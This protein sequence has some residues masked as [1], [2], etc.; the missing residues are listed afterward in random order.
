MA[1]CLLV[2]PYA[3]HL[4]P[5]IATNQRVERGRDNYRTAVGR[6]DYGWDMAW[7]NLSRQSHA[8]ESGS[9]VR[10]DRHCKWAWRVA[11][12]RAIALACITPGLAIGIGYGAYACTSPPKRK[13]TFL[14]SRRRTRM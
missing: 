10:C 2:H 9:A 11:D 12:Y 5:G 8:G 7:L 13:L 4:Y 3:G 6:C 14:T 1:G